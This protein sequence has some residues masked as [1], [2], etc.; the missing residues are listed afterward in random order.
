M[1]SCKLFFIICIN[2]EPNDRQTVKINQR[3]TLDWLVR[4]GVV[5]VHGGELRSNRVKY[6]EMTQTPNEKNK[7][8]TN[9]ELFRTKIRF[10]CVL[11]YK[12]YV[13]NKSMFSS[14][15]QFLLQDYCKL[16]NIF[17]ILTNIMFIL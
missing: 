5:C 14:N 11:C 7:I 12:I 6:A 17:R 3:Y 15:I 1:L 13:Y 9:T 10:G 16:T 4:F 2:T 8:N